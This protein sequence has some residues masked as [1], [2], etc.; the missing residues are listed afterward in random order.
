MNEFQIGQIVFLK[1]APKVKGAVVSVIESDVEN[2]YK[3]FVNNQI[4]I[5][6]WIVILKHQLKLFWQN[7]LGSFDAF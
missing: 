4:Q 5:Y 3:V 6:E 7:N 1:S 2:R